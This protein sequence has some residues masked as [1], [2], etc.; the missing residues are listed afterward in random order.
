MLIVPVGSPQQREMA[1]PNK[2]SGGCSY[3][4]LTGVTLSASSCEE[5]AISQRDSITK[6]NVL[7]LVS[8]V[9]GL[10]ITLT[11]D[12][13]WVLQWGE[14]GVRF[15]VGGRQTITLDKGRSIVYYESPHSVP[16]GP[17]TFTLF[18]PDGRRTR[19]P[20][21]LENTSYKIML[22]GL[23][24]RAFWQLNTMRP[25]EYS[26]ETS[27]DSVLSDDDVPPE[28]KIVFMKSQ[29]LAEV[30][31]FQKVIRITG[32]SISIVLLTIFYLKHIVTL[33]K[34]EASRPAP[35]DAL[36]EDVVI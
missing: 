17:V 4:P 24:G 1:T 3:S 35:E 30:Q 15:P 20:M 21:I 9:L 6:W 31:A 27:N 18:T 13:L 33:K 26:F 22:T 2:N 12:Q 10:V 16:S 5:N 32:A 25:G 8:V 28:D 36:T 29:T 23:S 19:V 11:L 14:S 34:R 7:A